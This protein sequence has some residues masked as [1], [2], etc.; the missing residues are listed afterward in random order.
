VPALGDAW[1]SRFRWYP[2]DWVWFAL[3]LLVVAGSSA[4]V[5]IAATGDQSSG[6]NVVVATSDRPVPVKPSPR[7]A[8][9]TPAPDRRRSTTA[10]AHKPGTLVQ[11]P[12]GRTAYTVVLSSFPSAAGERTASQLA[13]K[14]SREGLLDVGFLDSSKITSL[15]P[16]YFVV[17]SGVYESADDAQ[18]ALQQAVKKGFKK[19]YTRQIVS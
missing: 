15:H 7:Q 2:G 13:R 10:P 17:F 3:V 19:A 4:A 18:S 11:W 6:V 16:G 14:A 1:R 9:S 8:T 5:A 12:F